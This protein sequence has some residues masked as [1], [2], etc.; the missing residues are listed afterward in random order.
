[1]LLHEAVSLSFLWFEQLGDARSG[2][3]ETLDPGVV[4]L[5]LRGTPVT[6]WLLSFWLLFA[7]ADPSRVRA[8]LL[9]RLERTWDARSSR[10]AA[11]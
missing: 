10:R 11:Q 3:R 5:C 8:G 4:G 1:M 6:F 9:S 7:S 2:S